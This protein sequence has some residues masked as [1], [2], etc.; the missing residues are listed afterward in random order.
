MTKDEALK[1]ALEAL[2]MVVV[3]VKTTPTAYETHRQ[4]ITAI[5]QALAAP[6]QEPVGYVAENGVV[7]W[8]V[9]A[10]PILTDLYTT[11]PAA[12]V[13]DL[14]FGVSGGL[15]A[16][17]TLLSRDPCVH[18]NTAIEMIDAILKEHPAAP[19][20]E[21]VQLTIPEGMVLVPYEPSTEMQ[22]QGSTASGYDLSQKRAR[23][24]YQSMIDM[25][26]L[27]EGKQAQPAPTVQEP[28]A[29]MGTDIEGNPNKFRLNPFNGGVELYKKPQSVKVWDAEGY[30]ALMQELE[31]WKAAAQRQWV[32]LTERE[33]ELLDGMI[34]VQLDHAKR[35]DSIANRTMAE[36]QKGWDM[37][38]VALLKKLKENT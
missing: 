30:D 32:G 4:A 27:R 20:Q 11:P 12:V 28:V 34:E 6:V 21:P 36:K 29:W 16:I 2:E 13:Q 24:V 15:V 9:C 3:D 31:L 7:D 17:K 26:V 1:L 33:I 25:H 5:K 38:R 35:C 14:P 18:A 19:V 10:P 23:H 22:E 8:N 37:E